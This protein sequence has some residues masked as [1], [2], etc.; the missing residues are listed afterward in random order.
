MISSA[1]AGNSGR[2]TPGSPAGSPLHGSLTRAP[3]WESY[4]R[5]RRRGVEVHKNSTTGC[6]DSA[7]MTRGQRIANLIGVAAPFVGVLAA[8]ALLW[9]QWVDTFDLALL[10]A[11]YVV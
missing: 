7:A 6:W 2:R 9:N 11:T 3:L 5:T 10:A 8:I 1:S 4:K